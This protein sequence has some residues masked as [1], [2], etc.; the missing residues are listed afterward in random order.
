M[1]ELYFDDL[2]KLLNAYFPHA[3]FLGQK[4]N[5]ISLIWQLDVQQGDYIDYC[6]QKTDSGFISAN[7]SGKN[8]M[9]FL[10]VASP[11][12][13]PTGSFFSSLTD[14]SEEYI[15]YFH[16]VISEKD[17]LISERESQYIEE[18]SKEL[19]LQTENKSLKVIINSSQ[20]K[21][22]ELNF[23]ISSVQKQLLLIEDS[24]GWRIIKKYR[25]AMNRLFPSNSGRR[26]L[27]ES[28]QSAV[29]TLFSD[30]LPV[31]LKRAARKIKINQSNQYQLWIYQNKLS[32]YNLEQQRNT[33]FSYQPKISVI[34]PIF[35]TKKRFLIDMIKSILAQTY[36]NWEL[37]LVDGASKEK[38]IQKI[39]KQYSKKDDR[40]KVNILTENKGVAGNSNEAFAMATGDY[41]LLLDHDDTLEPSALFEVVK[42][43]NDKPDASFI[44]SDYAVTNEKNQ[45]KYINFCPDFCRF[46][47]LSHP[48]IVHLVAIKK[49][50]IDRIGGFDIDNFNS[51]VSHDVDLFLRIFALLND[52]DVIHIPKVLYYWR[53]YKRSTGHLL[54][55]KVHEYTKA[56]INRYI[57]AKKLDGYVEDGPLFNTF[58][59]R[60]KI[61][62]N[63]LISII[64]PT[65][66]KWQLLNKCISSIEMCSGYDNYEIIIVSN[67]T[68]DI[69]AINY[70][71][72]IKD[73]YTVL[74]YNN[75][76]NYSAINNYAV[77]FAKGDYFLFLNDDIEFKLEGSLKAMLELAQLKDVGIVGAKLLYPDNRIQHAGVIIG[78]QSIAEHSHK[79]MDAYTSDQMPDRGYISSLIAIRE[80]LAVTGAC[81]MIKKCVFEDVDGFD[82]DL[83]IG[84]GDIDLCLRVFFKKYKVLY[85]PYA[86]AYHHESAS[87]KDEKDEMILWHPED[88]VLFKNIWQDL[89]EKG[90]PYYNP[91]LDLYSFEPKPKIK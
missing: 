90:D 60:Y 35:N 48:Y 41:V 36:S 68:C 38:Y 66:D 43:I 45:V 50:I 57:D 54:N 75:V 74:N 46:F 25:S 47:Y 5:A 11:S 71:E 10:A 61:D 73:K 28:S 16:R 33:T 26:K 79:F 83:K 42:S 82:K 80:Y 6:I 58:R 23:Q 63:P 8:P 88:S 12:P 24:L 7:S 55:D 59:T 91:N 3:L 9:Y 17:I 31:L 44:Y 13:L 30:G 65:K 70:L 40:I 87:R 15:K 19:Q 76:F 72:S 20:G 21:I 49:N 52:N 51:G 37:C 86:M 1:K 69:K 14:I 18:K 4:V 32:K 22:E 53:H 78:L 27:Y 77:Q 2:R 89:I 85:T 67:N 64:I 56:A 39:L 81:L 34:V 29:K 84:L 62:G